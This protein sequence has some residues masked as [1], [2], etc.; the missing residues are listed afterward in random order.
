MKKVS[1]FIGLLLLVLLTACQ[2]ADADEVLEYHNSYVDN[3]M[4]KVMKIDEIFDVI[5]EDE[6]EDDEI[7]DL[8]DNDLESSLEEMK[9]YMNKQD[10]EGDDAKDYH[11]LRMDWFNVYYD[12]I[13]IDA[14]SLKGIVNDTISDSEVEENFE[15]SEVKFNESLELAE[16]AD[17]KIDELSDKYKFIDENEE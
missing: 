4:G 3:V 10:P 15:E 1:L 13:K 11:K 2:A 16:I 5:W 6:I 12:F 17:K 9:V 7:L 14:K 8:I